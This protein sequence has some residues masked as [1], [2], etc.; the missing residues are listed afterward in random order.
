[1]KRLSQRKL[2]CD[3]GRR[4]FLRVYFVRNRVTDVINMLWLFQVSYDGIEWGD[5][6]RM[7]SA[8]SI[9]THRPLARY[10]KLR[11]AHAPGM[12]GTFSPPP[13]VSNPAMHHGTCVTHVSW[14]MPG[15]LTSGFLWS[16]WRGKR[17][18]HSWRM[19]NPQ[20]YVSGKGPMRYA[21]GFVLVDYVYILY[22]CDLFTHTCMSG[23][24]W[25]LSGG[26]ASESSCILR[27][28]HHASVVWNWYHWVAIAYLYQPSP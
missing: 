5:L 6:L 26:R 24:R 25:R 2:L 19:R 10:V 27:E 9:I 22:S 7:V 17:S 3:D 23:L 4:Y 18:R 28:N 12:P 8:T 14:C 21:H 15:S 1:M 13:R 16:R 20:F 11:V